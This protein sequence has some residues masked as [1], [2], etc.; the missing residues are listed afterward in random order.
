MTNRLV[1]DV[2]LIAVGMALV[3]VLLL[4]LGRCG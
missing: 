3:E 2:G 4:L 1:I